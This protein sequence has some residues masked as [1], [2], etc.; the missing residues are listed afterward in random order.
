GHRP[1]ILLGGATGLVGD[2]SG[3]STERPLL[4]AAAVAHNLAGLQSI[5]SRFVTFDASLPNSAVLLNNMDWFSRMTVVDYLRDVGRYYRVSSMLSKDSVES[6]MKADAAAAPGSGAAEGISF[7]EFAYQ[8]LQGYD[9]Y[10][11]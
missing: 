5:F 3:R 2:P 9:F 11:L 1:I 7:T 6:R 4:D 10:E 8:T